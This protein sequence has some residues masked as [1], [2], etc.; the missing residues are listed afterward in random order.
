MVLPLLPIVGGALAAGAGGAAV[1][2]IL[3]GGK[4]EVHASYEHYAPTVTDIYSPQVQFAPVT[5]YAYQGATTII[6]SPYAEVS[7]KQVQEVASKPEQWG[8]WEVPITTSREESPVSG[9]SM[10]TIALI[11]VAGA[12]A[13]MFLK[14]R[15][16]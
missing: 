8:T 2:S 4:K 12:V 3:G 6:N 13:I 11:A 16:K 15:K 7:K 10:T 14:G 9:T 1:G 5:S